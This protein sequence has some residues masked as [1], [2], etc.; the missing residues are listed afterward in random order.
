[1]DSYE[2]DECWN[3]QS[4][5]GTPQCATEI[6]C[7]NTTSFFQ[8]FSLPSASKKLTWAK[9]VPSNT[10]LATN[11][12]RLTAERRE[13]RSIALGLEVFEVAEKAAKRGCLC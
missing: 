6:Q 8:V 7:R 12:I 11:D 9:P 13:L 10:M 5:A 2:R 1:M 3:A 4:R